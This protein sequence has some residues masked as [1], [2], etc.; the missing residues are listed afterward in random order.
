[1]D[2]AREDTIRKRAHQIWENEGR[3][4]GRDHAHWEEAER[5][6]ADGRLNGQPD[7]G[8]DLQNDPDIGYAGGASALE[9]DVMNDP[10]PDGS[11]N[12]GRRGRTNK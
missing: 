10:E 5:E 8:N 12:P 1:M 2:T 7:T 11:V 3:P 6:M 4:D 9:G